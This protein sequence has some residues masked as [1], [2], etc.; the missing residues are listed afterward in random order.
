MQIPQP[1]PGTTATSSSSSVMNPGSMPQPQKSPSV[2]YNPYA[3][4]SSSASAN[5]NPPSRRGSHEVD[6]QKQNGDAVVIPPQPPSFPGPITYSTQH[7]VSHDPAVSTK[8]TNRCAA[9]GCRLMLFS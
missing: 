2:Q 8:L 1:Y 3:T 7:A 9:D 6:A 4:S 5:V